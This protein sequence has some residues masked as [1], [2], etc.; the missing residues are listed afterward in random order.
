MDAYSALQML[1]DITLMATCLYAMSFGGGPERCGA[2]ILLLGS[3]LTIAVEQAPGFWQGERTE[4]VVIDL[5]LLLAFTIIA[6]LS[7]RFW[8]L[9]ATGFHLDAVATHFLVTIE[10]HGILQAYAL[11]QGWWAYPMLLA[12]TLGTMR[13][14]RLA[15]AQSASPI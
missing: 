2:A 14:R 6:L 11:V 13:H 1:Y 3:G 4:L 5:V 9:W 10:P 7:R 15:V 12:M 8:P